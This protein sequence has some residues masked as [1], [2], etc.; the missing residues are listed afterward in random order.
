MLQHNLPQSK[1][2]EE[3]ILGSLLIDKKAIY[4]V[5]GMLNPEDFADGKNQVIYES[6]I[7]LDS[8]AFPIDI[9]T[10]NDHLTKAGQRDFVGG[11]AYLA[12]L[13]NRVGSTANLEYHCFLLKQKS[14]R[15]DVIKLGADLYEKGFD[16]SIDDLELLEIAETEFSKISQQKAGQNFEEA[17]KVVLEIMKLQEKLQKSESETIGLP[18]SSKT[19]SKVLGGWQD[20]KF[21]VIAARPG[22]GK[23]TFITSEIRFLA[24]QL[25]IPV[26][27]FSLEMNSRQLIGKI[28]AAEVEIDDKLIRDFRDATEYQITEIQQGLERVSKAPIYINTRSSSLEQIKSG[29]RLMV[30]EKGVKI[31]FVDYI[32]LV[33]ANVKGGNREQEVSTIS[34]QLKLLTMELSIPIIALSQLSRA[35]EQRG[36]SKRP[37]LSDLRESG[38]IEQDADIVGFIYRPEYYGYLEDEEGQSLK[39]VAEWM[40]AK[41]REGELKNVKL[42][43][44]PQYSKFSEWIESGNT[45][46]EPEVKPYNGTIV[47]K[48]NIE[49]GDEVPF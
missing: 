26:G 39:G 31:V 37:M 36:G 38:A 10:V 30:R 16:D 8:K 29:I 46:F 44:Q 15:R 45:N 34:R 21:I 22:M 28:A 3:I 11:P 13:T 20:E 49:I 40:V 48:V 4:Q 2:L 47:K 1:D 12:E 5:Q 6:I 9:L 42:N 35:V 18:I 24:V 32:Q 43:F 25:G 7:S 17:H 27:M 33:S 41:N 14:V 23:T 19:L